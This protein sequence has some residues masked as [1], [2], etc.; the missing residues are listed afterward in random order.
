MQNDK[1]SCTEGLSLASGNQCFLPLTHALLAVA[2][3][4]TVAAAA[5]T[6]AAYAIWARGALAAFNHA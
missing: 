2:A 4:Y 3:A 5:A 1:L 6:A